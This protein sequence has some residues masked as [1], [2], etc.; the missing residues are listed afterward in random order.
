MSFMLRI[1]SSYHRTKTGVLNV[2]HIQKM[3]FD[4]GKAE[5]IYETIHKTLRVFTDPG[6][7]DKILDELDKVEKYIG[8]QQRDIDVYEKL[9]GTR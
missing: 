8:E 5:G 1:A 6:L 7:R 9:M 4:L 2:T 3:Y